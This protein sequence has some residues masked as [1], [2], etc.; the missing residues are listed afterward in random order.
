MIIHIQFQH[1]L[2]HMG[3]LTAHLCKLSG[4][5]GTKDDHTYVSVSHN[6]KLRINILQTLKEYI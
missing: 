1:I 3:G 2:I 4:M 5:I 6:L